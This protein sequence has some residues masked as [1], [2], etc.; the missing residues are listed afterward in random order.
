M[1]WVLRLEGI[2]GSLLGL[3]LAGFF[4]VDICEVVEENKGKR[5]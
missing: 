5:D 2:T 4:C 3:E 1:N